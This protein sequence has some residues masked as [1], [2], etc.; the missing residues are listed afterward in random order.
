MIDLASGTLFFDDGT[1]V[2]PRI[3]RKHFLT[4]KLELP[5]TPDETSAPPWSIYT[6]GPRLLDG[7]HFA[8]RLSFKDDA[9]ELLAIWNVDVE[10]AKRTERHEVWMLKVFGESTAIHGWGKVEA[11]T[12]PSGGN[13]ILFSYM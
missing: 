10:E 2:D 6:L 12:E 11:V 3:E 9:L 4:A 8:S 13:I 7:I 5:E 1:E